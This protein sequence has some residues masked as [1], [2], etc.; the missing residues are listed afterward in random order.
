M[1]TTFAI[2]DAAQLAAATG[3][4]FY[5]ERKSPTGE[6]WAAAV[7]AGAKRVYDA[8]GPVFGRNLVGVLLLPPMA[9]GEVGARAAGRVVDGVTGRNAG[10]Q[11]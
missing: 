8:A 3:G 5:G 10:G 4:I 9:I 2:L 7:D 1:L 6:R 11:P